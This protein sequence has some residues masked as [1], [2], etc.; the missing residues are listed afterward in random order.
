MA[1]SRD[2]ESSIGSTSLSGKDGGR[3][4][5]YS[6]PLGGDGEEDRVY[7]ETLLGSSNG[8]FVFPLS[9]FLTPKPTGWWL[10]LRGGPH[11]ACAWPNR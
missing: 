5:P 4:D 10:M 7:Q 6:F 1:G 8:P 11:V 2:G 3:A 9:C